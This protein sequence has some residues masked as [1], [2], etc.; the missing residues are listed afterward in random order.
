MNTYFFSIS[1]SWENSVNQICNKGH[2]AW[3]MCMCGCLYE[4]LLLTGEVQGVCVCVCMN[5]PVWK[6]LEASTPL[7]IPYTIERSRIPQRLVLFA[8]KASR[9]K[10]AFPRLSLASRYPQ[11]DAKRAGRR[12]STPVDAHNSRPVAARGSRLAAS[13]P[14]LC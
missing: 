13:R 9:Y 14:C 12:R 6:H 1:S 10:L 2:Y 5:L 7:I 11:R 3:Y 4:L 8:W